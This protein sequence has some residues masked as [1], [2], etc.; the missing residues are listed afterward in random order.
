MHEEIL[1]TE[2]YNTR[3]QARPCESAVRMDRPSDECGGFA[4]MTFHPHFGLSTYCESHLELGL[5]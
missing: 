3:I 4:V 5:D 2:E 1:S